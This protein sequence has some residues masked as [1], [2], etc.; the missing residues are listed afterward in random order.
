MGGTSCMDQVGRWPIGRPCQS[1]RRLTARAGAV[2]VQ[3]PRWTRPKRH[4]FRIQARV[5]CCCRDRQALVR[6]REGLRACFQR[7]RAHARTRQIDDGV[8]DRAVPRVRR[9]GA[10]CLRHAEQ[11]LVEGAWRVHVLA[12]SHYRRGGCVR[13][14]VT[15]GSVRRYWVHD[16]RG[17][18]RRGGRNGVRASTNY[19]GRGACC[20]LASASGAELTCD[21]VSQVDGM[22]SGDRGGNAELIDLIKA[23]KTPIV[24]CPSRAPECQTPN[25]VLRRCVSATTAT[26]RTFGR[27]RTAAMTLK[28]SRRRRVRACMQLLTACTCVCARLCADEIAVRLRAV[29]LC[30]IVDADADALKA[31]SCPA[32][33]FLARAR[34]CVCV[35]VRGAM[36]LTVASSLRPQ[37]TETSAAF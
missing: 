29:C 27:L 20:R 35:C 2:A 19:Y 15:G 9:A 23:T 16:A 8:R 31:V 14:C 17:R 5:R 24:R 3:G 33:L 26:S 1:P 28:S 22:S 18:P 25:S 36:S 10:E 7:S 32:S 6:G 13:L 34:S 11:V 37:P 12:S 21:V 30:E 4:S